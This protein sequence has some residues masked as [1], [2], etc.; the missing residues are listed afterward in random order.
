MAYTRK[1]LGAATISGGMPPYV[2]VN[3]VDDAESDCHTVAIDVR[4]HAR[5]VNGVM[6]YGPEARIV[7][8][9]DEYREFL[10]DLVARSYA[11][12]LL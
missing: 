8:R 10:R 11:E 6:T 3:R 2:S 4:G 9:L 5:E 1:N 7:L 12:G